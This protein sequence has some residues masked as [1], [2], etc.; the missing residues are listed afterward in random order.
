MI[1]KFFERVKGH[2][3]DISLAVAAV[4]ISAG[5]FFLGRLSTTMGTEKQPILLS[6]PE[7]VFLPTV[8]ST[9]SL[10]T[11]GPYVA[12]RNG[13][14]YHLLTC[15]GAKQIKEENKLFFETREAAEAAGYQPAGNCPGL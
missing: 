14:A 3:E 5:S 9:S 10:K 6:A 15:P 2:Q 4:L 11:Q 7:A 8:S 12:S 1:K 13:K